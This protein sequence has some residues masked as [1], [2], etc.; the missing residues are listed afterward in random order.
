MGLRDRPLAGWT[1]CWLLVASSG[2][3]AGGVPKCPVG[4]SAR[5]QWTGWRHARQ[6]WQD[7]SEVPAA[8]RERPRDSHGGIHSRPGH[9]EGPDSGWLSGA[10]RGGHPRTGACSPDKLPAPDLRPSWPGVSAGVDAWSQPI[11]CDLVHG[12]GALCDCFLEARM[13]IAM[14]VHQSRVLAAQLARHLL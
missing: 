7:S 9:T 4:P 1:S 5:L 11:R 13:R 8:D 14:P 10:P 3:W 6:R 12:A 2:C